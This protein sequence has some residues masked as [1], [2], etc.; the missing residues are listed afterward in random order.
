VVVWRLQHS[1]NS[2]RLP[3]IFSIRILKVFLKWKQFW[4]KFLNDKNQENLIILKDICP[5]YMK[6]DHPVNGLKI[7]TTANAQLSRKLTATFTAHAP[8]KSIA[9]ILLSSKCC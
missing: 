6:S 8:T 7:A 9:R 4:K 5:E 3:L 2:N 1:F